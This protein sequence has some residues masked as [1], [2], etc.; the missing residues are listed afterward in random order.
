MLFER[1]KLMIEIETNYLPLRS[2]KPPK[3]VS[4]NTPPAEAVREAGGGGLLHIIY[5]LLAGT[6]ARVLGA[7]LYYQIKS[8]KDKPEFQM[9]INKREVTEITE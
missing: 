7:W 2:K 6:T 1:E 4:K 9:R 8:V 3:G 5:T